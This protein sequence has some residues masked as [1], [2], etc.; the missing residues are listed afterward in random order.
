MIL[1]VV[2][3]APRSDLTLDEQ[4]AFVTALERAAHEIPTVR[5]V[6]IGRRVVHGQAYESLVSVDYPY[7]AMLEFDDV[8]GLRAYLAHPA[9]QLLGT[10]FYEARQAALVFD[11]DVGELAA[12]RGWLD[13][14]REPF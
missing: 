8:A 4:D 1:H 5:R 13:A 12:I 10:H 11:Y 6:R 3:F 2:L 14:E 7:A 9:H